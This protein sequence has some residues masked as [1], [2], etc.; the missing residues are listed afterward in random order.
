MKTL[1]IC[2]KCAATGADTTGYLARVMR[3]EKSAAICAGERAGARCT[4]R[5]MTMTKRNLCDTCLHHAVCRHG[6]AQQWGRMAHCVY[7]E[8]P[9]LMGHTPGLPPLWVRTATPPEEDET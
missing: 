1:T 7:Y 6:I 2:S 9:V 3:T 8:R 5:R 4:T